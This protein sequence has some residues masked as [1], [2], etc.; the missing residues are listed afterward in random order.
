VARRLA[1]WLPGLAMLLVALIVAIIV[2]LNRPRLAATG[3]LVAGA[4][5]LHNG[6]GFALGYLGAALGGAA[7]A[8]RRAIAIEVGM[9]N[10]GLATALALKF[11]P[12]LA[13][14]SAALFSVWQNLAALGLAAV[15]RRR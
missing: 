4:V 11:L 7:P 13:A 9:Q 1:R 14:L 5:V 6:F 8:Q 12:P 15:W 2:A 3:T 10:S